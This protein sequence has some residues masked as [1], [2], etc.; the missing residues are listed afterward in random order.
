MIVLVVVEE[1]FRQKY[2]HSVFALENSAC[3]TP[4][5]SILLWLLNHVLS[6]NHISVKLLYG[7]ALGWLNN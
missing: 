2:T 4:L 7:S 3:V 5:G 6:G 1:Q